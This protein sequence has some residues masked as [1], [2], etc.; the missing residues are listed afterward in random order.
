MAIVYRTNGGWGAGKGSKLTPEEVDGNFFDLVE[1]MLALEGFVLPD[2]ITNITSAGGVMQITVEGGAVFNVPLPVAMFTPR[3]DWAHPNHYEFLDIVT[4]PTLGG[5]LVLQEHDTET[6][7]DAGRLIGGDPVYHLTFPP[8]ATGAAGAAGADGATG[9]TG[10]TG[11]FKVD[12]EAPFASRAAHDD[13]DPGYVFIS[14]DGAAGAGLP[15]VM[16]IMGEGGA[17][18]WTG[19]FIWGGG[20]GPTGPAGIQGEPGLNFNVDDKGLFAGRTAHDAEAAGYSYLSTNGDGGLTTNLAVIYF[21]DSGTS[22]DWSDPID[23]QGPIGPAGVAGP[24]GP[25]GAIGPA[26]ANADWDAFGTFAQRSAYDAQAQG[27]T[28]LS[29]NGDGGANTDASLYIKNSATN[30]DWSARVTFAGPKG[31]TGAQGNPG[32]AGPAGPAGAA[33]ANGVGVAA[34]GS[35]G[36]MNVK[37]S[38]AD[39]ATGWAW[40]IES[41]PVALSNETSDITT[42][43]AKLTM[44]MPYKGQLVGL[45]RASLNTVSSSGLPTVDINKNGVTMLSTK[46]SIDVGEKT[47]VTAAAP[48][49]VSVPTFADDDELTFDID[50]A[51]TGARGLKVLLYIQRVP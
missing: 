7:F 45:P 51:G 9:P 46:L 26:G 10:P 31:N 28:Y 49:V 42:G 50:V 32:A 35:T 29:T 30:A 6:P 16:Y 43:V 44:R 40:P 34:G 15:A 13:E 8:G 4:V 33:G 3:G 36:Q 5:Y 11:Y 19:P 17:A 18:D 48:P 24:T 12:L 25:A 37:T 22:G 23:F 20:T 47:S 2:P 1:R 14:S 21:K 27:F 39:F 41:L 38:G